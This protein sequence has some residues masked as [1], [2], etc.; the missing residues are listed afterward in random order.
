MKKILA[1]LLVVVLL[2][3][4]CSTKDKPEGTT[5]AGKNTDTEAGI[6]TETGFEEG[7]GADDLEVVIAEDLPELMEFESRSIG[8]A[9]FTVEA[10]KRAKLKYTADGKEQSIS[11]TDDSGIEW[12]LKI[13]GNALLNEEEISITPLSGIEVDSFPGAEF[14]GI[15]LRP[16]GLEFITS[17]NVIVKK[18]GETIEGVILT[19]K[20]DGS[21]IVLAPAEQSEGGIK[22]PVQHFSTILF[23]PKNDLSFI[24]L[25]SIALEQYEEALEEA[26]ELLKKPL[27]VLAPPSISL[28]CMNEEKEQQIKEYSDTVLKEEEEVLSKFIAAD[29]GMWSTFESVEMND[30]VI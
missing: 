14:H 3:S 10:N 27:S 8:N 5:S 17:S 30:A 23:L 13:P 4:G 15:I 12:M 22:A 24:K 18:A 28:E 2:F 21:E 11:V 1:L 26:E 9:T 29:K 16:D 19:G 6:S 7:Y 20:H 25:Q